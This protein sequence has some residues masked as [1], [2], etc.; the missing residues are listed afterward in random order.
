M[1]QLRRCK[2]AAYIAIYAYTRRL[3]IDLHDD[4][5]SRDAIAKGLN[6]P[7]RQPSEHIPEPAV[8]LAIARDD[9]DT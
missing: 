1:R 8:T 7:W 5:A 2:L 9:N 3:S 6:R 4:T